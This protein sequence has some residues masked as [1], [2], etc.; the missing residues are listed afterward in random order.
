MG[1]KGKKKICKVKT[2]LNNFEGIILFTFTNDWDGWRGPEMAINAFA[3]GKIFTT[4]I[5][6]FNI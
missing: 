6:T 5:T 2:W 3:M 4:H 1:P